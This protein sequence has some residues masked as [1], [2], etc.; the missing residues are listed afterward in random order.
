[1]MMQFHQGILVQSALIVDRL[2]FAFTVTFHYIFPQITMGLALLI[3]VLETMALR[4]HDEHY[5][6]AARFWAK[7]FG[8]NFAVGVFAGCRRRNWTDAGHGRRVF[9]LP[10]IELLGA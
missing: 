4:T 2:Q 7:I 3:V 8:I 9:F 5:N 10:R 1:M 6:R